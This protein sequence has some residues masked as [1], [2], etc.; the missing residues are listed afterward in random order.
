MIEIFKLF[1]KCA[2]FQ[3]GGSNNEQQQK[4][5]EMQK[6]QD[7]MKNSILTQ[8]LDQNARARLNTVSFF[9]QIY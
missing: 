3:G 7:D 9:F 8:I 2:K 1:C 5:V 6:Q 4:A